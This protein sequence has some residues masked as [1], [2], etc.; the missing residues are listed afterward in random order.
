MRVIAK[1]LVLLVFVYLYVALRRVYDD[2]RAMAVVKTLAIGVIYLV[3]V[4]AA[5]VAILLV[6]FRMA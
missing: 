3:V 1:L 4:T 6:E 5:M 2:S